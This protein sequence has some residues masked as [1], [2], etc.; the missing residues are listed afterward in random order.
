ML[1]VHNSSFML[2]MHWHQGLVGQLH[3]LAMMPHAIVP[4]N[5]LAFGPFVSLLLGWLIW[6]IKK[7]NS[8]RVPL[9]V[10]NRLCHIL[11]WI[12]GEEFS[13]DLNSVL[14][15]KVLNMILDERVIERQ[16]F[17]LP[18]HK[19]L[20]FINA[21]LSQAFTFC[22]KLFKTIWATFHFVN[23]YNVVST[24]NHPLCGYLLVIKVNL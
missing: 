22:I 16:A 14:W 18:I 3:I 7:Q 10:T 19:P 15:V 23:I 17:F 4:G 5:S 2:W 12:V 20:L 1:F 8:G 24:K 9:V 11:S 21:L 13:K 6:W